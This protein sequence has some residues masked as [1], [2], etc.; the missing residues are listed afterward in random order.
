MIHLHLKRLDPLCLKIALAVGIALLGRGAS[1]QTSSTGSTA[2]PTL[3]V[4][5]GARAQGMGGSFTAVADD[6]SALDYNPA[7]FAQIQDLEITASHNTYLSDGFYDNLVGTYPVATSAAL[8]VGIRYFNYGSLDNRDASGNLLGS[9]NPY[10][11]GIQGAFGFKAEKDLSLG[12]G[13]HWVRQQ[14]GGSAYTGL[15]WDFG[16]LAGPWDRFSLGLSLRNLGLESGG[17]DL[18]AQLLFGAAWRLGLAQENQSLLLTCGGDLAFQGVSHLNA[19]FE[20][21]LEKSYFLR[22]G[23]DLSLQ[24]DQIGGTEGPALGAGVKIGRFQLDYSFS[25]LGDFGSLQR[26]SLSLFLDPPSPKTTGTDSTQTAPWTQAPL[27]PEVPIPSSPSAPAGLSEAGRPVTLRFK[28]E[29]TEKLTARQLYELGEQKLKAGLKKEALELYL[30]AVEKDPDFEP[31]LNRL[32]WLYFD[33]SLESYRKALELDPQ[34]ERLRE[35]LN[36]FQPH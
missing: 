31:A 14:I 20:Y 25:L 13:T 16:L 7:G 17:A 19:G 1:A 34:N 4:G 10:D 32:G 33:Q 18:P 35:W 22:G 8:A 12:L 24:D 5:G 26:F 2:F 36:R 23:W 29:S 3:S 9:F 28:V 15:L 30:K 11:L 6:A 21:A 27:I